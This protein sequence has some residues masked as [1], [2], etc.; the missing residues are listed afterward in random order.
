MSEWEMVYSEGWVEW[1]E[2]AKLVWLK[3]NVE[4][5]SLTADSPTEDYD[6]DF[7]TQDMISAERIS[8]YKEID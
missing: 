2:N 5:L 3:V 8:V 7:W 1:P 6:G 4:G